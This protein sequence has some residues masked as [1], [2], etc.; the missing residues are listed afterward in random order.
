M[1][2]ARPAVW[3][4]VTRAKTTSAWQNRTVHDTATTTAMLAAP[5]MTFEMPS[6]IRVLRTSRSIRRCLHAAGSSHSGSQP[7][8]LHGR[9][10][11]CDSDSPFG[12]GGAARG[13]HRGARSNE[14]RLLL[15]SPALRVMRRGVGGAT[16]NIGHYCGFLPLA[17]DP[18]FFVRPVTLAMPNTVHADVSA[19]SLV[20]IEMLRYGTT[21]TLNIFLHW[22]TTSPGPDV[23]PAH[24]QKLLFSANRGVLSAAI[25]AG[26]EDGSGGS[27]HPSVSP[28][29]RRSV[30]HTVCLARGG[31]RHHRRSLLCRL[32][33]EPLSRAQTGEA[34]RRVERP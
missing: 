16:A 25:V 14:G 2:S 31:G 7:G 28:A 32:P 10:R 11:F 29:H 34:F 19:A 18:T 22:L 8:K 5:R 27:P 15:D 30:A 4:A 24:H 13:G 3:L 1:C 12:M 6:A 33:Q 20:S 21:Y 26:R 9:S 23:L 17:G